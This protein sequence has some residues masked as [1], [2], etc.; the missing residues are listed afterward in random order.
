MSPASMA[1]LRH[2]SDIEEGHCSGVDHLDDG[3]RRAVLVRDSPRLSRLPDV[4]GSRPAVHFPA[5]RRGLSDPIRRRDPVERR[6]SGN[7]GEMW[8]RRGSSFSFTR[9]A[10]SY[11]AAGVDPAVFR[12][13]LPSDQSPPSEPLSRR[14]ASSLDGRRKRCVEVGRVGHHRQKDEVL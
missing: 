3:R 9:P 13:S 4:R 11:V 8:R 2:P 14:P 1:K 7:V 12:S 5:G 6:I 10:C